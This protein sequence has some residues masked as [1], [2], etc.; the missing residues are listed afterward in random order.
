[1]AAHGLGAPAVLV[2]AI[3][4]G[5]APVVLVTAMTPAPSFAPAAVTASMAPPVAL[6]ALGECRRRINADARE[7]KGQR[8]QAERDAECQ[9][10]DSQRDSRR[11][12]HKI[13]LQ[14][15]ETN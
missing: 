5:A 14:D 15:S 6:T 8:L 7:G 13:E 10:G 2:A 4:D 1:M 12:L 9:R 3:R 11:W